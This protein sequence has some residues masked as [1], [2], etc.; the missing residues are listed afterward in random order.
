[1][2]DALASRAEEGRGWLRKA[3]GSRHQAL[4]RGYPNGGTRL[5]DTQAPLAEHIGQ[6]GGTVGTETSQYRQEERVFPE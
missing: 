3:S 2:V 5:G 1:M 6:L 4:S